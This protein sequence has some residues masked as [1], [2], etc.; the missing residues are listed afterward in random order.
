MILLSPLSEADTNEKNPPSSPFYKGG[1]T[2]PPFEKACLPV[3]RGGL[4]KFDG[5][6]MN[7][8]RPI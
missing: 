5:S 4:E 8:K 2:T 1:M 7:G 3:G 6:S